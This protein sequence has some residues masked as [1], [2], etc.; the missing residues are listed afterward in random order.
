MLFFCISTCNFNFYLY[1]VN[2]TCVTFV[3]ATDAKL[4]T[5]V[6]DP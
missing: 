6:H 1:F 4:V 3:D 5:V 2:N